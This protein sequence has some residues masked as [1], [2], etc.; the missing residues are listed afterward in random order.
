MDWAASTE[1]GKTSKVVKEHWRKLTLM[2]SQP[3]RRQAR[4]AQRQI[5]ERYGL[6][7]DRVGRDVDDCLSTR[8]VDRIELK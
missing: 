7:K 3:H 1:I 2:R 4:P 6:E 8:L 5:Q